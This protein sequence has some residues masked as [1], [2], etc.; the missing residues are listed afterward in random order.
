MTLFDVSTSHRRQ[1]KRGSSVDDIKSLVM[2]L[3]G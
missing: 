1:V 3:I 2:D